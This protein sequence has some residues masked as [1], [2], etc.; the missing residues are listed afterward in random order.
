MNRSH[1]IDSI[2]CLILILLTLLVYWQIFSHQFVIIDDPVY[3]ARNPHVQSGLTLQNI[4][5]AFTTTRAEFWHPLTWLS[6][7]LDTGL[8]GQQPAGYLFTN[9]FLHALNAVLMFVLFK[10]LTH[11][12][13]QS[14]LVAAFFALHPLHV[15]SVAWIAERKD[16]LSSFF[17]LLTMGAYTSY[18]RNPGLNKML[19]LCLTMSLGLMAKPM[20]VTL[21]FVL[22]L[23]DYWPLRRFPLEKSE[24]TSI[25][26]VLFLI[27][28]KIP[29]F[30]LAAVFSLA[31]FAVQKTGGGISSAG[32]Y[33]LADRFYNAVISYV[34]YMLKM[35]W[36]RKL[37]VFYPF[38]DHFPI[39]QIG[40]AVLVLMAITILAIRSARRY[41]FFIVGWLWYL[42][43]LFPVIGLI[44]IGDFSMADRYTYIPLTGLFIIIAW[45]IPEIIPK[46]P[47]KNLALGIASAIAVI[48]L[49]AVSHFQVGLWKDSLTLFDH[50]LQVTEKNYYAHYGLGHALA[51][52]GK[53]DQAGVHFSKAVE[54]M[55]SKATLHNDLGRVLAIQGQFQKAEIHFGKALEIKPQFPAAHFNLAHVLIAN[56][57]LGPA[58]FHFSEAL[59]LHP[60]F[61]DHNASVA[62]LSVPQYHELVDRVDTRAKLDRAVA[63]NRKKLSANPRNLIAVRNLAIL[64]SVNGNYDQALVLLQI[65]KSPDGRRRDILRGFSSWSLVTSR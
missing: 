9:L 4:K 37:A 8:F 15:E 1:R 56:N 38:P 63:K 11:D 29:L 48:V 65:D 53:M 20:L 46:L 7:M 32:Q 47:L 62:S 49:A 35:A 24:T 17:W 52:Q 5:W 51:G 18:T 40:A 3:V 2:I 60:R 45:G 55:P 10:T 22:L 12:R 28:E 31:A 6:Y 50:A 64:Y 13:W 59:R 16:V 54:L 26:S 34:S 14:A 43:T 21:P 19:L 39:W 36:P 41:P 33:P 25:S 58:I 30:F 23:L 27:R 57:R 44:K 61:A 42:G